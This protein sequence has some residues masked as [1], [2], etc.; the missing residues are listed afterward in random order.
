MGS[1]QRHSKTGNRFVAQSIQIAALCLFAAT[2][3]EAQSSNASPHCRPVGGTVMTNFVDSNTTLGSATGDLEG[4][5]SATLLGVTPA[6][7]GTT[8]FSVQ[9]HW[10]TDTGDSIFS[11]VAQASALP[12]APGLFAIVSYPVTITGGTGKFAGAAGTVENIGEVDLNA[13]HT[14]FRYQGDVCFQTPL[15]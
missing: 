10:T 3:A 12:V 5:V 1:S 8:V 14:V 13:L 9:H 4:A 15:R 6:A 7:D 11:D 2:A